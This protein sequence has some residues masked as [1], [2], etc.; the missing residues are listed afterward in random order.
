MKVCIILKFILLAPYIL[1]SECGSS[2]K[3]ISIL[4]SPISLW[5]REISE[6]SCREQKGDNLDLRGSCELTQC[7][8]KTVCVIYHYLNVHSLGG[9]D[10]F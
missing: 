5:C 9:G 2:T 8:W 3:D 1:V 4:D 6:S 10:A 7:L